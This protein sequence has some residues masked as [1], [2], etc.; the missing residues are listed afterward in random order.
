MTIEDPIEYGFAGINQ[1]QVN[2]QAGITFPVGLRAIMRLDPDVI[3][4]GEIRDTETATTA[5]QA[6]ITGHL[7]LSSIHANDG[8][9]SLIRLIDM[10]VEPFLVTSA[11]IGSLSQRLVRRVCPYC[12]N[13]TEVSPAGAVAYATAMGETRDKFM[14]GRGCNFCS[15]SGFLGRVG[16]Y[17]L[18]ALTDNLRKMVMKGVTASELKEQAISEGMIAMGKDGMQKVRDGLTTPGEIMKNV[19]TI[20]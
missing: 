15:R 1:I 3:L 5:V 16:V 2:R 4:V 18:L 20:V 6:A 12:R 13:M 19:F 17:E 14:V 9:S 7:V 10:G 8:V 11:V